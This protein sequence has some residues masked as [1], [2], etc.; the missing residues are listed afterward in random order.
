MASIWLPYGPNG[1]HMALIGLVFRFF[2]GYV[3]KCVL[4]K[5]N[6]DINRTLPYIYIYIYV[7]IHIY[8]YTYMYIYTVYIYIIIY[9]Y[10]YITR[11]TD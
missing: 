9:I 11:T 10:A 3:A 1:C 5:N 6:R 8:I 7:Y 4:S 2:S